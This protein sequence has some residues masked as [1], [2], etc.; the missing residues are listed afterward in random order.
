MKKL[1]TFL[2]AAAMATL[3][4]ASGNAQTYSIDWYSIDGG[5][6]TSSGG[7]YTV[8]GTIGQPDAGKLTGGNYELI[9]GFMSIVAAIQT[10]G[11]PLLTITRAGN[12][13]IVSW[14][15][16]SAGFILQESSAL[17]NPSSSTV[18]TQNG[19]T[20]TVN[21]GNRQITITSPAGNKYFRLRHP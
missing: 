7:G 2:S 6:G 17:A 9:G 11:A 14:P 16:P 4:A 12:N 5:G 15:D 3:L 18:W 19:A 13:I 21:G 20:P 8:T 10:P 1:T